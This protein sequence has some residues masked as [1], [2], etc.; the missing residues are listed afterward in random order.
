M[1][2][3]EE[4]YRYVVVESYRESG[5]GLHGDVHV[6]PVAAEG[7]SPRMRVECSK[8]LSR[9]YPVGTR[10]RIKAKLTDKE[11]GGSSSIRIS[12]GNSRFCADC[13][14]TS[15]HSH[16]TTMNNEQI[17]R[18]IRSAGKLLKRSKPRRAGL[19]SS[20]EAKTSPAASASRSTSSVR[21]RRRASRSAT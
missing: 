13:L 7:F 18:L 8:I 10:F 11:E 14:I 1:A 19:R 6:R 17:S 4:A 2:K 15:P 21:S 5:S 9:D 3:P 16:S 20:S 12:A